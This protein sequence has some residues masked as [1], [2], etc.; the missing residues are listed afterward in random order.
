VSI[1]S[2]PKTVA[3]GAIELVRIPARKLLG[4][5]RPRSPEAAEVER[6]AEQAKHDAKV[7]RELKNAEAREQ[8][9]QTYG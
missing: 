4:S 6:E 3:S 2:L 7:E 5:P 9:R 8:A 1:L